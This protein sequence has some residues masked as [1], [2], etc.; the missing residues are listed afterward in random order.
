MSAKS[1]TLNVPTNSRRPSVFMCYSRSDIEFVSALDAKLRDAN[2]DVSVDLRFQITP[3]YRRELFE[4]ILSADTLLFVISPRS[5]ESEHCSEEL[6]YAIDHNKRLLAVMHEDGFDKTLL[7]PAV[8]N[9]EWVFMRTHLDLA[10]RLHTL[11]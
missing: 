5:V 7:H 3:D 11:L 10:E 2:V 4:R 1:A 8:T 6:K 9:P